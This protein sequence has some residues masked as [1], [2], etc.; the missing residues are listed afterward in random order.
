V[1]G[2]GSKTRASESDHFHHPR[3]AGQP[4]RVHRAVDN[5]LPRSR[6]TD[7]PTNQPFLFTGVRQRPASWALQAGGHGFESR[8]LHSVVPLL[9]CEVPIPGRH[10]IRARWPDGSWLWRRRTRPGGASSW[11][12]WGPIGPCLKSPT[13]RR[14]WPRSLGD[15]GSAGRP[16]HKWLRRDVT[17]GPTGLI[18]QSSKPDSRPHQVPPSLLAVSD[19]E[20]AFYPPI[21]EQLPPRGTLLEKPYSAVDACQLG[22]RTGQTPTAKDQRQTRCCRQAHSEGH[23]E[24]RVPS[25]IQRRP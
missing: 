1:A 10:A 23:T 25:L 18:D 3:S 21:T 6:T 20:L 16:V 15:M 17:D 22:H 9:D 5:V 24:C 12:N 11:W 14:V 4:S 13:E 19:G 2:A 7:R 8:H